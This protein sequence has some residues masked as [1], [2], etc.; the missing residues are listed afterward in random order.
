[1]TPDAWADLVERI[2]SCERC[3]RL[4]EHR[5]RVA[6]NPPKRYRGQQYWARPLP[7]FG[8]R[9]ARI[10][11]VGLAPAA[12]G[13]NRTGRMFTGDS[14]AD[15]LMRTLHSL[16]LASMPRSVSRDDGLQLWDVFLTAPVR[17]VPPENRPTREELENCYPFLR[18]EFALLGNV[19][20]IVALGAIGFSAVRRLLADEGFSPVGKRTPKFSH[21]AHYEFRNREGRRIHL[22]ASYHPSRQNTNT[23]RL[24][25]AMFRRVFRRAIELARS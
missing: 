8:D 22:L 10:L 20:V 25:E 13:G 4:V 15:F 24:T 7:G 1:M 6:E 11:V 19:R 3:P 23:G 18:E 16:G 21:G 12:H 2:V 17:C 14:S 9:N 5:R